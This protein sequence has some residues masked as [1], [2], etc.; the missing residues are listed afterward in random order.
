VTWNVTED[1]KPWYEELIA[2]NMVT[3]KMQASKRLR[4]K[5]F[6]QYI[7]YMLEDKLLSFI[8]NDWPQDLHFEEVH[9]LPRDAESEKYILLKEL[10]DDLKMR[11]HMAAE[12]LVV[13]E[14]LK[15]FF[16]LHPTSEDDYFQKLALIEERRRTKFHR[17][18]D[19]QS[20]DWREELQQL[21]SLDD[22]A[23]YSDEEY[24]YDYRSEEEYD[25]E[26]YDSDAN[27][28]NPSA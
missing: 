20:T 8:H 6:C 4:R 1:E 2:K 24:E 9:V 14:E 18:Q 16:R 5:N 26:P 10:M 13:D 7:K 25:D 3:E 19:K 17:T 12:K 28:Y 15:T 21:F 11:Q 22:V 23:E 27:G